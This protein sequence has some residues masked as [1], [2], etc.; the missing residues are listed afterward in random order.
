MDTNAL[1]KYVGQN[2]KGI[3]SNIEVVQGTAKET[4]N[5]YY[6]IKMDFVNGYSKRLFLRSEETFAW[7]NAFETLN[8]TKQFNIDEE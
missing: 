6:C 4:G 2:F 3:I 8:V 7:I 5:P 1:A